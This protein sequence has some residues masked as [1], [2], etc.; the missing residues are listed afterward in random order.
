LTQFISIELNNLN[1][2]CFEVANSGVVLEDTVV[3]RYL[4]KISGYDYSYNGPTAVPGTQLLL[5]GASP[6]PGGTAGTQSNWSPSG[7]F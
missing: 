3:F 5:L 4:I 7:W 6:V 2:I 1:A